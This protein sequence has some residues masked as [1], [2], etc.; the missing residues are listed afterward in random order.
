MWK[1]A[2]YGRC[3]KLL[4]NLVSA[5]VDVLLYLDVLWKDTILQEKGFPL[6][7]YREEMYKQIIRQFGF[8]KVNCVVDRPDFLVFL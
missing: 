3:E 1:A 4:T 7:G 6:P 8:G 2:V 5:C